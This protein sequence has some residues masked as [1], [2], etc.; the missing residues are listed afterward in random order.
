MEEINAEI[1]KCAETEQLEAGD[2]EILSMHKLRGF[3]KKKEK[4]Q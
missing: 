4:P 1:M 3:G 2:V